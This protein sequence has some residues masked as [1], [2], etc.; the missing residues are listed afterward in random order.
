MIFLC[1]LILG[2][3]PETMSELLKRMKNRNA[4]QISDTNKDLTKKSGTDKNSTTDTKESNKRDI[5]D[6]KNRK[7]EKQHGVLQASKKVNQL[8]TDHLSDASVA[9]SV[10]NKKEDVTHLL[11]VQ[12]IEHSTDS[13]SGK[14][15]SFTKNLER[16]E[17]VLS[18]NSNCDTHTKIATVEDKNKENKLRSDHE[19]E[20]TNTND[21]KKGDYSKPVHSS[22]DASKAQNSTTTNLG[23]IAENS[24][25]PATDHA[26][27]VRRKKAG[28]R[29]QDFERRRSFRRSLT[30]NEVFMDFVSTTDLTEFFKEDDKER[31][32][33]EGELETSDVLSNKEMKANE[34][35]T[36]SNNMV[37]KWCIECTA[38][39]IG[40]DHDDHAICTINQDVDETILALDEMV[41]HGV[42]CL[43]NIEKEIARQRKILN[44]IKG[45]REKFLRWYR[46]RLDTVMK[47]VKDALEDQGAIIFKQM[48]EEAVTAQMVIEESISK[49]P[50]KLDS[51][52]EFVKKGAMLIPEQ[53]GRVDL[54]Q[55]RKM[56]NLFD[57]LMTRKP[58]LFVEVHPKFKE[59]KFQNSYKTKLACVDLAKEVMGWIQ[60]SDVTGKET[61]I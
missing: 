2:I 31:N 55:L 13:G 30:E 43:S 17:G 36:K 40:A 27:V 10:T 49:A 39:T 45:K 57:T 52:K 6:L 20:G 41:E 59:V 33:V 24:I 14:I 4:S 50:P 26:P 28:E 25:A 11:Q 12:I 9:P 7:N 46:K 8:Q 44:E 22:E 37:Y 3:L 23:F 56:K 15:D 19:S 1:S 58:Q 47:D 32:A 61:E 42:V 60:E 38:L 53:D 29:R 34:L 21:I 18:F 16:N 5:V 51:A 54:A 35:D 48:E